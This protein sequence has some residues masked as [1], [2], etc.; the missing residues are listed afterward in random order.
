LKTALLEDSERPRRRQVNCRGRKGRY[1]R[2]VVV[3]VLGLLAAAVFAGAAAGGSSFTVGQT[4]PP[5][6]GFNQGLLIFQTGV[7]GGASYT[8]PP[9]TWQVTS[10]S[11]N[12]GTDFGGIGPMAAV[13]ATPTGGGNYAIDAVTPVATPTLNMLN[14]FPVSLTVHGGDVL[15]VWNGTGFFENALNTGA[16]GDTVDF[17]LALGSPPGVGASFST[18][19]ADGILIPVSVTLE[20][21][22]PAHM[23]DSLQ[24][25][26]S[27]L[28]LPKGTSTALNSSLRDAMDAL[29]AH[30]TAGAC[31]ALQAFL[32]KVRAQA[33]KKLTTEQAQEL[34][35]AASNIRTQLGC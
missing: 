14:T 34:I 10:W 13:L 7:S 6:T 25:T 24:A 33:G 32:N 16:E 3:R 19:A 17:H 9:G 35:S 11:V 18:T 28:G 26:V 15:G 22:D 21:L 30:D 2:R 4:P 20:S 23:I 29:A 1:M 5:N 12:V 31:A 27:G 8:V